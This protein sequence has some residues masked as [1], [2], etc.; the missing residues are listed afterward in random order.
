MRFLSWAMFCCVF[1]T[2]CFFSSMTEP[3]RCDIVDLF[4]TDRLPNDV[5]LRTPR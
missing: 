2:F 5:F 3:S 1:C 4:S